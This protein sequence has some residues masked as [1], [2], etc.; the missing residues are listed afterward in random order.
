ME[1]CLSVI[2]GTRFA[3]TTLP[4]VQDFMQVVRIART[5]WV[6]VRKQF[7]IE[8]FAKEPLPSKGVRYRVPTFA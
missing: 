1:I 7:R 2:W 3:E 4:A 8:S 6:D 5:A